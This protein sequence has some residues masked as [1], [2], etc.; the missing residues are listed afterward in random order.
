M[1][2]A[3]TLNV[4]TLNVAMLN[5]EM[6]GIVMLNVVAPVQKVSS[7]DIICQIEKEKIDPQ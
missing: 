6:L 1:L 3:V 5:L 2:N 7:A 4:I